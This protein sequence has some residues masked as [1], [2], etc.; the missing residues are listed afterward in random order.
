MNELH[1][2]G[3]PDDDERGTPASIVTAAM[4][5]GGV[6]ADA[7]GPCGTGCM[8]G[9]PPCMTA[10]GA[11]IARRHPISHPAAH[12]LKQLAQSQTR[13][14]GDGVKTALLLAAALVETGSASLQAGANPAQLAR[15]LHMAAAAATDAIRS[16]RKSLQDLEDPLLDRVAVTAARGDETIADLVVSTARAM[17]A[18]RIINDEAFSLAEHITASPDVSDRMVKGLMIAGQRFSPNMPQSVH[19]AELLLIDDALDVEAVPERLLH[20]EAGFERYQHLQEQFEENVRKLIH[21]GVNA[22]LITGDMC[23]KAAQML[24][25]AGVFA[26]ANVRPEELWRIARLLG[27][28]PI[29]RRGLQKSL[30]ELRAV[31]GRHNRI[32]ADPA[33]ETIHIEIRNGEQTATALIGGPTGAVVDERRLLARTCAASIQAALRDGI[34]PGGGAAALRA[35]PELQK[36]REDATADTPGITCMA[37]ALSA[38]A[39]AIG[40]NA[41][42]EPEVAVDA[43]T[44]AAQTGAVGINPAIGEIVDMAQLNIFDAASVTIAAIDAAAQVAA[45]IL[46]TTRLYE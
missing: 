40:R 22:V 8:F 2:A 43:T 35:I 13:R 41:G 26:A 37:E 23:G 24:T 1:G 29:G 27:T 19:D 46:R 16:H 36:L 20:T 5:L 17:R 6:M 38:P 18:D 30:S 34:C 28:A 15:E 32:T 42:Y 9:S 45:R 39:V 10:D 7:I 11:T 21:L 12:M 44:S 4:E 3:S 25:D 14:M 31:I 33:S